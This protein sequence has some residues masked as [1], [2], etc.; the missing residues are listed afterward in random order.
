[1][2]PLF[3]YAFVAFFW[4]GVD[5]HYCSRKLEKRGF[6][7]SVVEM[8]RYSASKRTLR[9]CHPF[10][11]CSDTAEQLVWM[12]ACSHALFNHLLK[13]SCSQ[14]KEMELCRIPFMV[15]K[16]LLRSTV[17]SWHLYLGTRQTLNR[18]GNCWHT[19]QRNGCL[20]HI[21]AVFTRCHIRKAEAVMTDY[22]SNH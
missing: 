4:S 12:L 22:L 14:I 13:V 19:M 10:C 2:H 16:T 5:R 7:S 8:L 6:L 21:F 3:A 11:P 1:M 9:M 17:L 20:P 18:N 15:L